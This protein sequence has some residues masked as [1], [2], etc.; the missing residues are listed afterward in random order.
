[1]KRDENRILHHPILGDLQEQHEV[2]IY[3]NGDPIPALEGEP[4]AAALLA[5]GVKVFHY[6]HKNHSPRAPFCA[7]GHCM[8]CIMRVDGVDGVRTCMEKVRAGMRVEREK[9]D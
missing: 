9:T 7:I 1:M 2:T 3:F 4:V 6:S 8:D 5:A